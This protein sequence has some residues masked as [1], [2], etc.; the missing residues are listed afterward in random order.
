MAIAPYNLRPIGFCISSFTF[1]MIHRAGDTIRSGV[2]QD[3]MVSGIQT[4]SAKS[5][6]YGWP[7]TLRLPSPPPKLVYL[8]LNQWIALA[9]AMAGHRE[10]AAYSEVLTRC[11][12]AVDHGEAVFPISDSIYI[13]I[14]K[15][16][17]H[18]QRRDLL[19][20]IEPLS[21]FMVVT[22]R[23]IV[24]AHEIEAMLDLIAGPSPRPINSME[25]LDWG[26]ARAFGLVGGFKVRT[27]GGEDITAAV[28]RTHRDGPDAFDSLLGNAE[29]ELNRRTIAGP[30]P[31]E[32]PELREQL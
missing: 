27:S 18:R 22:C 32:E 28:R 11:L 8:D 10:G 26:V 1:Q 14:S 29:L 3:G 31:D 19:H 9:K 4:R 30:A 25:Y 16:G 17:S 12:S 20:V 6:S 2:T 23:S 24:S 5:G 15:N 21:R 13:E 7:Q